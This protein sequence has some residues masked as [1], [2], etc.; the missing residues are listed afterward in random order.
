MFFPSLF[1]GCSED[2]TVIL[3]LLK[4]GLPA[5]VVIEREPAHFNK[6]HFDL[7]LEKREN[8]KRQKDCF[9]FQLRILLSQELRLSH[10][11]LILSHFLKLK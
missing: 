7:M 4:N 2:L 9:I 3:E 6:I 5:A 1:Y 11:L 8:K 10:Y